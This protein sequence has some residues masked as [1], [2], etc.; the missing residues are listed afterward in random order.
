MFICMFLSINVLCVYVHLFVE[1]RRTH[2][3]SH[4]HAHY[5]FNV[6]Q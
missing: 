4:T 1:Q 6:H 5:N 3:L 2:L